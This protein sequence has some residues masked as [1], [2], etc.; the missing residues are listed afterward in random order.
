MLRIFDHV[1]LR[2]KDLKAAAPFYQALLPE[3]GFKVRVEIPGWLQFESSAESATEF[4][5]LTEDPAHVANASRIA[6]WAESVT[7]V[8]ELS[9]FVRRIGAGNVEGP[10]WESPTYYAVYFEDPSGN[11]L[12]ICHRTQSFANSP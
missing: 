3:L 12:E 7:R 1:D 10:G 5:G 2:V 8:D 4:F 11:R 9:G 6:F